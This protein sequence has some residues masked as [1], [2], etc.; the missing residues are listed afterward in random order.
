M[1]DG[2]LNQDLF[3]ST[4]FNIITGDQKFPRGSPVGVAEYGV[5]GFVLQAPAWGRSAIVG[6]L[7]PPLLQGRNPPYPHEQNL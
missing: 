4:P 1:T 6:G 2:R 3:D 5:W 7:L